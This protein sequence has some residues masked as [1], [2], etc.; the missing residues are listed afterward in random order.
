MEYK[1]VKGF[2]GFAQLG[3]LCVFLGL[4]F[5]LAGGAQLV[6]GMKMI[7]A[8]TAYKDMANAMLDAMT[9]PEN[10][11]YTRL[12]QVVGS[13]LLL[14]VPAL[15]FSWVVN[16]RNKFWLGFN[17]YVSASQILI[18]FLIIFA[19][20]IMASPF[21]DLSKMILVH[22]PSLDAMAKSLEN[23][24]NE[25]VAV[26]SNLKSWPE[27]LMAIVIM[28]FF[29]ALFEEIFFRGAVQGLLV[30]WLKK[31]LI[32]ILITSLVF[33]LIHSSI[34][35]FISRAVLGFALGLLYQY[36]KNI[37]VNVIAH[38]LNNAIALTQLFYMSQVKQ[39]VDTGKV[40]P[41]I[42][43][44]V[45]VLALIALYFLFKQLNK[46]SLNNR[47]KIEAKEAVISAKENTYDP[48]FTKSE[49]S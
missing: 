30:R 23:A 3:I 39:K 32:A 43:W 22:F 12:L 49:N 35:L 9:R 29:P 45:A 13:L 4:G 36:T 27:F 37:W 26:L 25:Q 48:F 2:T 18:G 34:Y 1:S 15:L 47:I 40:D 31:P 19:A 24:Y 17:P 16:G 6:I 11:G 14:F 8:G 38:F 21:E 20:N 42:E 41:K 7:P 5:I 44:W 33:S 10:V 46:I 28:A